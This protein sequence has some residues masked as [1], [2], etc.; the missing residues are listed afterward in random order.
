MPIWKALIACHLLNHETAVGFTECLNGM[1]SSIRRILKKG[2]GQKLQ[3]IWEEQRSESEIV[4]PKR[5]PVFCPKLG[6]EH[7]KKRSSLKFGPVFRPK[8]VEEQK[9]KGLHSNLV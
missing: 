3:K 2:G 1:Y 8:L 6:E 7:K 5:N 4:P 9:R